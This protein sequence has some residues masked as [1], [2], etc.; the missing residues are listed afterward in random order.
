MF[1]RGEEGNVLTHWD[2]ELATVNETV[3]PPDGALRLVALASVARVQGWSKE[4]D[5]ETV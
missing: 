5:D 1:K 2:P 4:A 3:P